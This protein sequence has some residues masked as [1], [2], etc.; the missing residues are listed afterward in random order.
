MAAGDKVE[1]IDFPEAAKAV[2]DY[3]IAVLADAPN[4][5]R[6]RRPSST[7]SCSADGPAGPGGAGFEQ[8]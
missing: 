6:A 2:N 5:D 3:P 8:P 4:A 7:S 1:G